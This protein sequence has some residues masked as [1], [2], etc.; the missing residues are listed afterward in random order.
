M[1]K[2]I[3]MDSPISWFILCVIACVVLINFIRS[4]VNELD[5]NHDES[6]SMWLEIDDKTKFEPIWNVK[7]EDD[8][9]YIS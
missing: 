4:I 2:E 7:E 1:F 8:D 6:E 3:C 5:R 9:E